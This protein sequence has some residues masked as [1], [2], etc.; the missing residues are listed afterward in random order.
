[1]KKTLKLSR[2]IFEE[3]ANHSVIVGLLLC[4][5]IYKNSLTTDDV[6]RMK[7][8]IEE[9]TSVYKG[10]LQSDRILY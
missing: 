2:K 7:S 6:S 3:K 5:A 1:M 4:E 8:L 9:I 10:S